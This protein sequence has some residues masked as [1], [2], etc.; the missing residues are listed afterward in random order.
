MVGL[1][2]VKTKLARGVGSCLGEQSWAGIKRNFGAANQRSGL[3]CNSTSQAEISSLLISVTL[4]LQAYNKDECSAA[5]GVNRP[6]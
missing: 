5:A 6:S 1:Q 2:F 3:I 4:E